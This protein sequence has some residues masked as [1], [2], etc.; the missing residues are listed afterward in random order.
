MKLF[1]R[2]TVCAILALFFVLG[3]AAK[4]DTCGVRPGAFAGELEYFVHVSGG[5]VKTLYDVQYSRSGYYV[6][7]NRFG[8][9]VV[10]ETT[11][12]EAR[13]RNKLTDTV[14]EKY[15]QV[16]THVRTIRAGIPTHLDFVGADNGSTTIFDLIA[17]AGMP[18]TRVGVPSP[19]EFVW[20]TVDGC[21]YQIKLEKNS[22]IV[23]TVCV[24]YPGMTS[25]A[26]E[27]PFLEKM[28][29]IYLVFVAA[30]SGILVALLTV[31]NAIRKRKAKKLLKQEG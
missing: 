14:Y 5:A 7:K 9:V 6:F 8:R 3:F 23:Q 10:A 15:G 19:L 12:K 11:P 28:I 2:I 26:D 24:V 18:A 4:Y 22:P 16:I 30:L 20:V 17:R 1:L 13:N 25:S 21:W 27:Q 31:P 29:I